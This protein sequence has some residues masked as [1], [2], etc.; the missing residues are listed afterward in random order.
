MLQQNIPQLRVMLK[1]LHKSQ[2]KN[3]RRSVR[4]FSLRNEKRSFED[5]PGCCHW[6]VSRVKERE[7]EG[8]SGLGEGLTPIIFV[9]WRNSRL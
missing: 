5:R 4:E 2:S 1:L 8:Q 6:P 7:L 9:G 3:N